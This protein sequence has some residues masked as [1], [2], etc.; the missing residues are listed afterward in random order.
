[1]DRAALAAFLAALHIGCPVEDIVFV[2]S[3]TPEPDAGAGNTEGRVC[4]QSEEC[5]VGEDCELADRQS[6]VRVCRPLSSPCEPMAS[7]V[8]G[9]DG[10]TYFNDCWRQALGVPAATPGECQRD[11]ELC[12]RVDDDT[13]PN[14]AFC[15]KLFPLAATGIF[16]LGA[17]RLSE[18]PGS[19]W[20]VP[21]DCGPELGADRVLSSAGGC[22][23]LCTAV[24]SEVPHLVGVRACTP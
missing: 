7:I 2:V 4:T 22:T 12:G 20:W 9:S 8:C 17:A 11:A 21:R 16:S 13:C 15:A 18:L 1:M 5:D 6:M 24:R 3:D 19:C 23:D 14:G 10:V